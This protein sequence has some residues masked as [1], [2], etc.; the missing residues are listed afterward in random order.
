MSSDVSVTP[1]ERI[2]ITYAAAID[3]GE[4]QRELPL[5]LLLLG[6]YRQDADPVANIGER[7]SY[8]VDKET[9][10]SAMALMKLSL[11]LTVPNKLDDAD[12]GEK[13]NVALRIRKLK[14]LEPDSIARQVPALQ[15]LIRVRQALLSL[16]GPLADMPAAGKQLL[17]S[18]KTNAISDEAMR[19]RIRALL[20]QIQTNEK[21]L[22]NGNQGNAR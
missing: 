20:D 18:V 14:D 9:L 10:D 11:N 2:N 5:R 16:K 6:D 8:D 12:N 3:G 17:E 7:K 21:N 19:S 13:L 4:E 15:E 22:R 1:K